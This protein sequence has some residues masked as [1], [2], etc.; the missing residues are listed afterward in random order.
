LV[1]GRALESYGDGAG[2]VKKNEASTVLKWIADHKIAKAL[3]N[4]GAG[5]LHESETPNS[6]PTRGELI[7][8][9]S[10]HDLR[11]G[12]AKALIVLPYSRVAHFS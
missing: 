4:S 5:I 10:V 7:E 12:G 9:E 3:L 2:K 11:I 6:L 1:F 8:P